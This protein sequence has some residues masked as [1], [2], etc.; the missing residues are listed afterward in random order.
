MLPHADFVVCLDGRGGIAAACPPSELSAALSLS[1]KENADPNVLNSSGDGG[2]GRKNSDSHNHT[3][4]DRDTD[5]NNNQ[6]VES[7][8][9]IDIV[10]GGVK[11][12]RRTLSNG[13][14]DLLSA[15]PRMGNDTPKEN[16]DD[17]IIAD[18]CDV[19]NIRGA[20]TNE[21]RD[22]NQTKKDLVDNVS[23]DA[24]IGMTKKFEKNISSEGQ[25]EEA[26]ESGNGEVEVPKEAVLLVGKEFK[27][28]GSVSL[29]IYCFY[30]NSGGGMLAVL[31]VIISNLFLPTSWYVQEYMSSI[32]SVLPTLFSSS[33]SSFLPSFL[34]S[35][36]I[37]SVLPTCIPGLPP[38]FPSFF[39]SLCYEYNAKP[40]YMCNK[41]LSRLCLICP[42]QFF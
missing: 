20:D 7:R 39:D 1:V 21:V 4:V 2:T 9:D 16:V 22:K 18:K 30:F 19:G 26:I 5:I 37:P 40:Y 27:G 32:L 24:V 12:V 15:L 14:F 6:G 31:L 41:I 34:S 13:F 28:S 35:Y 25:T 36:M 29:S 17:S 8:V 11:P 10:D 33:F 23:Q 3:G 38:V 42:K